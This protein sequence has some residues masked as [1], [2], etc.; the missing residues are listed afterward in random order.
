MLI[1][2]SQDVKVSRA[3]KQSRRLNYRGRKF[4]EKRETESSGRWKEDNRGKKKEQT[5]NDGTIFDEL[6]RQ[7][8]AIKGN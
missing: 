5:L 1:K 7:L 3:I 6:S 8:D 2:S 4:E